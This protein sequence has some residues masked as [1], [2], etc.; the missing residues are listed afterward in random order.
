M[1]DQNLTRDSTV[2]ASTFMHDVRTDTNLHHSYAEFLYTCHNLPKFA[3]IL[4]NILT[5]YDTQTGL[6]RI[7]SGSKAKIESDVT[8]KHIVYIY[9]LRH[10]GAK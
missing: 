1:F 3:I 6:D 2:H 5:F 4:L 8:M 9:T 10:N 7:C